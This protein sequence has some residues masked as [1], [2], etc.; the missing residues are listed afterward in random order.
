MASAHT[1]RCKAG[2]LAFIWSCSVPSNVGK[3]VRVIERAAD[4][5]GRPT[6]VI[7]SENSPLVYPLPDGRVSRGTRCFC[8][9]EILTPIASGSPAKTRRTRKTVE[10]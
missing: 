9:D 4:I 8:V 2:D 1:L 3:V 10:A 6:W 7:E 5:K